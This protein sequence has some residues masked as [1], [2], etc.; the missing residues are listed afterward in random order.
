MPARARS[1]PPSRA[2]ILY[3]IIYYYLITPA[4]HYLSRYIN[5]VARIIALCF[6]VKAQ[7]RDSSNVNLANHVVISEKSLFRHARQFEYES[8][9]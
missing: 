9:E 3:Y 6:P 2:P 5:G 4:L 1:A 7:A 8:C